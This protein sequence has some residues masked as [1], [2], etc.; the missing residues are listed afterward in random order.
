MNKLTKKYSFINHILI[1]LCIGVFQARAQNSF[2]YE[3][4]AFRAM[5]VFE[6]ENGFLIGVLDDR[7]IKLSPNGELVWKTY[8][9]SLGSGFNLKRS[10]NYVMSAYSSEMGGFGMVSYNDKGQK[11]WSNYINT[12]PQVKT[13]VNIIHDTLRSQII[14]AGIKKQI[15]IDNKSSYWIAGVDYHG[16]IVWENYWQDSTKSKY[17][18]KIFL[19]QKTKG[20][21]LLSAQENRDDFKELV[22]VDSLGRLLNKNPV[23]PNTCNM[24]LSLNDFILH[25]ITTYNDTLLIASM[26]A[27][28]SCPSLNGEYFNFYNLKGEM[29]KSLKTEIIGSHI[30]QT[31]DG[32]I[33][34]VSGYQLTKLNNKLELEWSKSILPDTENE[35]MYFRKIAQ[36]RDGGYYG[37]ADGF[38]IVDEERN[39]KYI[40]YFFKT[41]DKGNM[42]IEKE[43]SKNQN[44]ALVY[45]NPSLNIVRIKI[46]HYHGKIEAG[47]YTI[48]GELLFH[49]TKNELEEFDISQLP[50]GSYFIKV[51][52]VETN[53]LKTIRLQ[54]Q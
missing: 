46:P 45:P 17:F 48:E 51:R 44:P 41:D 23:F 54:V 16:R 21:L 9:N 7:L 43:Y 19:N 27:R 40:A 53:E 30:Q 34:L 10:R 26:E 15:G 12:F 14:V 20:Y 39:E 31:K 33:I 6:N 29:I 52:L 2:F 37:I 18:Q 13:I 1:I 42:S 24:N 49:Q 5:D 25:D 4:E 22:S 36:S 32:G 8:D 11:V 35:L 28:S 3:T 38:R 47:F 50:R